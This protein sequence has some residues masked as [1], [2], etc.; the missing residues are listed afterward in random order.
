MEN[1]N[2]Y[3]SRDANRPPIPVVNGEAKPSSGKKAKVLSSLVVVVLLAGLGGTGYLYSQKQTDNQELSSQ[4]IEAESK[5]GSL[6]ERLDEVNAS[7]LEQKDESR[8]SLPNDYKE[9]ID[10]ANKFSLYYPSSWKDFKPTVKA[11]KDYEIKRSLQPTLK[12]SKNDEAWVVTDSNDI[13]TYPKGT[14]YHPA[15]ARKDRKLTVYDFSSGE[16]DCTVATLVF[17]VGTNMVELKSPKVCHDAGDGDNGP[18]AKLPD[19]KEELAFS[20]NIL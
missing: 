9:Y 16:A 1:N 15:V 20:I 8:I 2:I 5:A 11:A 6:Q 12:Y 19:Q 7:A 4:L 3:D 17:M 10:T 14:E 13:E 18:F